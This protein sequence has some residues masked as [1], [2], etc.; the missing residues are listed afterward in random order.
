MQRTPDNLYPEEDIFNPPSGWD[1]SDVQPFNCGG[2][3]GTRAQHQITKPADHPFASLMWRGTCDE[4][5]LT[6]AGFEDARKHGE[7]FWTVYHDKLHFVDQVSSEELYVRTGPN[8]RTNQ[9]ASAL[10]AGMDASLALK[11]FTVYTEPATVR[12][13]RLIA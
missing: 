13:Q 6:R 2:P 7:D 12:G 3:G 10:L 1:C 9:V 5:Q 4:G 11:E 8:D